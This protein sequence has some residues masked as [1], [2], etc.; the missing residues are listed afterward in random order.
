MRW[1]LAV[2]AGVT[3]LSSAASAEL[4]E[5]AKLN[6]YVYAVRC[7]AVAPFAKE[8]GIRSDNGA[9]AFKAAYD[10]GTSLGYSDAYLSS[11]V[12]ARSGTEMKMM[13]GNQAYLTKAISDCTKLKLI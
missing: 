10:L 12:K 13:N 8:R 3:L 9:K 1:K 6:A 7:F 5:S 2:V 4:S 11:D